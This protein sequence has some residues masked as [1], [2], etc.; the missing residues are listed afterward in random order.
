MPRKKEYE[1]NDHQNCRMCC[2]VF[3]ISTDHRQHYES[4]T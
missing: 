2:C 4:G 1:E 3:G